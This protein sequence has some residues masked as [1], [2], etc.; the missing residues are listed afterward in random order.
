LVK[1]LRQLGW[2]TAVFSGGFINLASWVKDTL[3]LDY[4][5]ANQLVSD[6]ERNVL[7]GEL[8]PDAPIIHAEKKRELLKQY[9]GEL[10]IPIER[11]IAVGDGSN[12]LLMMGAAGLGIAFNAKPKVQLAAPSKLNTESLLDV[13]YILGYTAKEVQGLV[14]ESPVA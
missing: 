9:A 5:H 13:M 1:A 11:V 14:Q 3:G 7:T 2:K 4:A 12:D 6:P 10:G 8:V